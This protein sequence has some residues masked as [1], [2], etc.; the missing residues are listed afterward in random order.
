MRKKE[1]LLVSQGSWSLHRRLPR[2][3][4]AD[5]GVDTEREAAEV[6]EEGGV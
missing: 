6:C 2:P 3:K 4:R 5:R 1:V